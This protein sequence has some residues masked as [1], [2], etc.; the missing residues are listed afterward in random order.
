MT[1]DLFGDVPTDL[2]RKREDY[3]NQR[4][5]QLNSLIT[6]NSAG[7]YGYLL[8]VNGGGAVALLAYIGA[9]QSIRTST[10]PYIALAFF[11]LGLIF[12]GL[13]YAFNAH[14][15]QRL[16]DGWNQDVGLYYQRQITWAKVLKDDRDRAKNFS[17]VPW[18]LPWL[19]FALFL[20][21]VIFSTYKISSLVP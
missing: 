6:Q 20:V 4:F 9:V 3:H 19:A 15:L 12:V 21:G 8:S 14:N 16:Q 2:E 17:W 7:A 1:T 18:V 11:M 13:T 10:W 5:W